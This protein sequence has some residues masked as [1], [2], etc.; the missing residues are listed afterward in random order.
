MSDIKIDDKE[1]KIADLNDIQKTMVQAIQRY[2]NKKAE[3]I[4]SAKEQDILENYYKKKLID[5]LKKQ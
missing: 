1:Y 4:E 2:M 5:S 3:Y